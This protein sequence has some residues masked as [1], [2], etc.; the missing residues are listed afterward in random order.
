MKYIK[1][2]ITK[3]GLEGDVLEFG[4]W[5]GLGMI[6]L[7]NIFDN[8]KMKYIGIDSFE[9]LPDSSTIWTKESFN[10]TSEQNARKNILQFG[11]VEPENLHLIKGWF[12]E[13]IVK[14]KLSTL[15]DNILLVHLDADLGSSTKVALDL[16][17]G[18]LALREKPLYLLFDDW[19]CHPDEVPD[20]FWNWVIKNHSKYN[21]K[22]IKLYS[23]NLIRYYKLD[24]AK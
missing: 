2:E 24:F 11:K 20:A 10:D 8:Y 9:G 15:S 1:D 18:F 12:D 5:Q 7:S 13:P 22:A 6:Y 14:K 19:G 16:I 23:T 3:N 21:F 4:T 17:E